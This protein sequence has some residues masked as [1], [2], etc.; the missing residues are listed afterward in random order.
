MSW[1][2]MLCLCSY[3]KLMLLCWRGNPEERP[4]FADLVITIESILTKVADYLD[5]NDFVLNINVNGDDKTETE[6]CM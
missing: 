6:T 3:D 2:L 4:P 1:F 5:F